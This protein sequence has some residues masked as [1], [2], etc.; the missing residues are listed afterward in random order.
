[1]LVE[2]TDGG[3]R[4][5]AE[6]LLA[7]EKQ[8]LEMVARGHSMPEILDA[9]CRLVETTAGGCYCSVVLID[10]SGT[11]LAHGAAPS[12]PV[13]FVT[14]I[15][16]RP[17]NEDSGPCA[18]AAHLN[19]QVISAD[20][21]TET[22]WATYEWCPMALAH[23]LKAC[24]STPIPS[25]TGKVLGAFALYFNEPAT[26]T[27]LH[28]ELIEQFTHIA[29]IAIDSA[30]TRSALQESEERFRRMADTIQDVIWI[31]SL[32]PERVIYCSPS[33]ER[34][35]GL[36]VEALVRNPRLWTDTI[37]PDDRERVVDTFAR[38][39]AGDD[40][41]YHDVEFRIVQPD[42]QVRWIN[43]RGVL[44]RDERG[45]PAL[46][47]G[48]STDITVRKQAEE[49]LHEMRAALAHVARAATLGELTASI[50]HE[51]NQPLAAVVMNGN[52]CLR[53]L[54][55]AAPNIGEARE[56]ARR[57]TR[58]GQ[59]A[60]DVIGR[61]QGLFRKAETAKT[62]MDINDAIGD[63]L[64]LARTELQRK[65]IVLRTEFAPSL[66]PAVGDRVQLQQVVLNLIINAAEA[67]AGVDDRPR[68]ITVM[69]ARHD[70]DHILIA[71]SDSGIGL[72]GVNLERIF[73]PFYTKK[74]SG[75]GM[76]LSIAR[77][78][79]ESHGGRLWATPRVG[80][81]ATFQFTVPLS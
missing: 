56:A 8:L 69:T 5:R 75:M 49:A 31:T 78:I 40:V 65:R 6:P 27:L 25:T 3:Y 52:A 19:E 66:R 60:A 10:P 36:S 28:Q 80:A 68:D 12:L 48:I 7:A 24:W 64:T 4:K 16:G 39:I 70:D 30:R 53:W 18:M 45:A 54:N 58:E 37:H 79:V 33:F 44:T 32:D 1:M 2:T 55:A 47:S 21:T 20:L 62:E 81:G 63:V 71:V 61:L 9:I 43:E 76:G 67:L 46:V 57:A 14:S 23:G 29:S 42:G 59:R 41:S 13:S 11:R 50:A 73:E 38:W 26:P 22:R 15:I 34:I 77:S 17:V 51:V 72:G 74:N 35:W